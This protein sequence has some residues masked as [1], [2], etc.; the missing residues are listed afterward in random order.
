MTH[1]NHQQQQQQQTAKQS[2]YVYPSSLQFFP[3]D[4]NTHR[5]TIT[6]YN[7]GEKPIKFKVL[8]TAPKRYLV[9]EPELRKLWSLLF[10]IK[11]RIIIP[12][13]L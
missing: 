1:L 9:D 3:V 10:L 4:V 5:Q 2:I 11:V 8:S 13:V 7:P 6:N 12:L